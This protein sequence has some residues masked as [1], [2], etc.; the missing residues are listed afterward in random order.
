MRG[1]QAIGKE[2]AGVVV[3]HGELLCGVLDKASFGATEF[4][5]VHSVHAGEILG[6]YREM[7]KLPLTL[8][9]TLTLT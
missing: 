4:G 9:L 8:T 1:A 6:R 3:R 2:E 7:Y 5:L